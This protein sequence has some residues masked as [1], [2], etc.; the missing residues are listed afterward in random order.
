MVDLP[1]PDSPIR[2][3]T[4]PFCRSKET[5]STIVTR[6]RRLA[7]RIAGRFDL[8]VANGKKLQ[9]SPRPPLRLDVRLNSQSTTRL[10]Q[11][12]SA[13]IAAAGMSA[14]PMPKMMP[15]LFSL[16]MPPQSAAGGWM[17]RP[18]KDSAE[19]N[20]I[21]EAEAQAELGQQWRERVGQDLA[22]DDPDLAFAAQLGRLDEVHDRDIERR[23]RAPRRID[24]ASNR[25][26]P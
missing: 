24:A 13:A 16:T 10:T 15:S 1:A 26:W 8:Q 9:A 21:D 4:L 23:R 2:P 17:P 25:G 19:R 3:S 11:T 5:P 7:G 20:R 12:A 14:A 6:L 22:E 18:R